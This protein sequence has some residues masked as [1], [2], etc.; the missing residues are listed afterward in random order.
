MCVL[1]ERV[2]PVA[3]LLC[4]HRLLIRLL[5]ANR[6]LICLADCL[7]IGL[8]DTTDTERIVRSVH[9]R[10]ELPAPRPRPACG[11]VGELSWGNASDGTLADR[12]SCHF[13]PRGERGE[14]REG[15]LRGFH[16]VAGHGRRVCD[17]NEG[18]RSVL[19]AVRRSAASL[20]Y[21][22]LLIG[23]VLSFRVGVG[24]GVGVDTDFGF[25]AG[26]GIIAVAL[27]I[28]GVAAHIESVR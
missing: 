7:S 17:S 18:G 8:G 20:T 21:A 5:V 6:L 24:V 25:D 16:D 22:S 26:V 12:A 13:Q 10:P 23:D 1:P 11:C 2:S 19:G 3:E 27:C 15:V 9:R 14:G 4:E 28:P